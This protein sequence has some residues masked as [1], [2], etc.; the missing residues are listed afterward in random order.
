MER[1]VRIDI[2]LPVSDG[3]TQGGAFL[4]CVSPLRFPVPGIAK[5]KRKGNANG[6]APS[7]GGALTVSNGVSPL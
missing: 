1:G 4:L 2:P 3:K 6:N 7:Q 5:E